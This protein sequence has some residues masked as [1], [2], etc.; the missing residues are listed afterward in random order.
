MN[1]LNIENMDKRMYKTN[2]LVKRHCCIVEA[3]ICISDIISYIIYHII[4]GKI[5]NFDFFFLVI[6][7]TNT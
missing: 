3:K 4:Y 7:K 1:E 2:P 5:F 6:C